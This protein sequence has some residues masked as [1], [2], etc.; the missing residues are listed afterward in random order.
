MAIGWM[1]VEIWMEL[2]YVDAGFTQVSPRPSLLWD[3]PEGAEKT[4]GC[5]F[6]TGG[7][8]LGDISASTNMVSS[9]LQVVQ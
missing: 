7:C 9:E 1:C 3:E 4:L 6:G 8:G 2:E 5:R